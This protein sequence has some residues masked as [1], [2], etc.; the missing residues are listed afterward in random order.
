M[1]I[2]AFITKYALCYLSLQDKDIIDSLLSA[3]ILFKK[4]WL[5][6]LEMAFLI[7]LV[8]LV[9]GLA[10]ALVVIFLLLPFLLLTYITITLQFIWGFWL[11]IILGLLIIFG[12]IF[13]VGGMLS[14]WQWS[15]WTLLFIRLEQGS[16]TSKII[17]LSATLP[18][19]WS[20][21]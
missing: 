13:L 21:K 17:R 3:L 2:L 1:L 18:Q 4:N 7:F 20:N 6:S 11:T 12:T 14:T 19:W 15:A 9:V 8:S 5:V 10:L 16:G